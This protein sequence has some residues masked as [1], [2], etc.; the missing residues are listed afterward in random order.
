MVESG[1]GVIK[2]HSAT[3]NLG[4]KWRALTLE[5]VTAFTSNLSGILDAAKDLGIDGVT[6]GRGD[7]ADSMGLKL[8]ED[9]REVMEVVRRTANQAKEAGL[10]VTVGGNGTQEP[11]LHG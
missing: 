9:S 6:I 1:F 7:L 2:F 3:E 10:I 4:F 5:T 8:Q 11:K